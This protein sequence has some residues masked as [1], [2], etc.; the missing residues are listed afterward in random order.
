M[1]LSALDDHASEPGGE[2][3][4]T[5]NGRS[6]ARLHL[7]T[8]PPSAYLETT[9]DGEEPVGCYELAPGLFIHYSNSGCPVGIEVIQ[10][11]TIPRSS[12]AAHAR[13]RFVEVRVRP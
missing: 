6:V 5:E 2:L 13:S 10:H 3:Y 8:D 1:D 9:L 12:A 11:R 4:L 7:F